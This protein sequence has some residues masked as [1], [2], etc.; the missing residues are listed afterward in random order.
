QQQV[1]HMVRQRAGKR[2]SR[3]CSQQRSKEK[4]NRQMGTVQE[5]KGG[6]QKN[7]NPLA[8]IGDEQKRKRRQPVYDR[9]EKQDEPNFLPDPRLEG[10]VAP[11]FEGEPVVYLG[12]PVDSDPDKPDGHKPGPKQ[13]E[14]TAESG[15]HTGQPA[16]LEDGGRAEKTKIRHPACQKLKPQD[17][18]QQDA[19]FQQIGCHVIT[20]EWPFWFSSAPA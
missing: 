14:H 13:N 18:S 11:C 5:K 3:F 9:V 1:E 6:Q 16:F 2:V 20:P 8:G 7:G 4:E 12:T 17:G 15:G 19:V 10:S